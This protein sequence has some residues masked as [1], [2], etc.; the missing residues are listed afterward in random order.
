MNAIEPLDQDAKFGNDDHDVESEVARVESGDN[1]GVIYDEL[2]MGIHLC[3]VLQQNI[4]Q[5]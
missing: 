4:A 1:F 2:E 5:V 3:Y